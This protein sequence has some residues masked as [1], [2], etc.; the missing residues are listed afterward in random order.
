MGEYVSSTV[1]FTFAVLRIHTSIN[2]IAM[3]LTLEAARTRVIEYRDWINGRDPDAHAN[4][5][6]L[7]CQNL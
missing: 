2:V 3:R 5:A 4:V 7:F 1:L 6:L